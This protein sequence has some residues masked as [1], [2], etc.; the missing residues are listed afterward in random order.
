MAQA[1]IRVMRNGEPVEGANVTIGEGLKEFITNAQ[2]RVTKTVPSDWGP[3]AA[4][5]IIEGEDFRMGGGPYKLERD[6]EL[7]IEV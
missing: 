2:G 3:I 1:G 7:L 5:I 6:V 4:L